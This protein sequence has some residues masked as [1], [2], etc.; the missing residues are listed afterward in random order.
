M[1]KTHSQ[2]YSETH[3]EEPLDELMASLLTL[4]THHSLNQCQSC[5]VNI[6]ERLNKVCGHSEIEHFPEQMR[7]MAKMRQLWRTRLF[8]LEQNK[9]QTKI[10]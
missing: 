6:V 3:A 10:H 2:L 5:A 7:V 1:R 8:E 4:V 9:I